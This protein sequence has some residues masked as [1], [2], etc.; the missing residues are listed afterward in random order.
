MSFQGL[1]RHV[2]VAKK[3]V[4][5]KEGDPVSRSLRGIVGRRRGYLWFFYLRQPGGRIVPCVDF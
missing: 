2:P 5:H 3:G 1:R 4:W